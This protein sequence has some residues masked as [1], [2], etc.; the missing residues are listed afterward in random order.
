MSQAYRSTTPVEKLLNSAINALVALALSVPAL[1]LSLSLVQLKLIIVTVFFLENLEAILFH[2]YQLPGMRILGTRWKARYSTSQQLVHAI[3]YSASFSSLLFWVWYPGDLL[4]FNLLCLQ[5][6]CV[7][8]T[9]T[10]LHGL[11]A[12]K[13]V[14]VKNL[15]G[16]TSQL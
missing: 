15:D 13:M 12:G 8:M 5:L 3:L 16:A 2:N 1:F 10:T 7:L 6:P 11:L 9:G 14:D 4:L